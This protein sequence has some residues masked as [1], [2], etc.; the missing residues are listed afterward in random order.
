MIYVPL[1]STTPE[2][3]NAAISRNTLRTLKKKGKFTGRRERVVEYEGVERGVGYEHT[4]GE[5]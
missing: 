2:G 1:G 4:R 3:G 5:I